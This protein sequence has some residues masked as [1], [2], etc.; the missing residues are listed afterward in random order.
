MSEVDRALRRIKDARAHC[1]KIIKGSKNPS[2]IDDANTL[3][4]DLSDLIARMSE[5][6]ES[7]FDDEIKNLTRQKMIEEANTIRDYQIKCENIEKNRKNS[8]DNLIR[9]IK[10]TDNSCRDLGIS[11]IYGK[12]PE[13]YRKDTSG[14]MGNENRR[15]PGVVETRHA[16][17]DWAWKVVLGST[18]AMTLDLAEMNYEKNLED[19]EKIA[20]EFKR[21][22]GAEAAKKM[23]DDMTRPGE[24]ER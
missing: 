15:N 7:V 10:L 23:I 9:Q 3:L 5:Y 22:G 17:A 12:L 6:T 14:L 18:V 1:E 13:E 16:I 21:L 8:H 19:R 24:M 11:E 2:E 20:E 4:K